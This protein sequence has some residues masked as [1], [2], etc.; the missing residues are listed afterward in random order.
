MTDI[1]LDASLPGRPWLKHYDPGVPRTLA[2]YPRSTL[3]DVV[4]EAAA[5]RPG[6][7]ALLF[8]GAS[9]SYRELD[10]LTTALAA[11]LAA[12]GV[13]RGE[14]VALVLPNSPQAIIAQFGAWKAGTVVA[15][16]NPLYTE[17]ELEYALNE[18]GAET[19][20]V[21]TPFYR[22]VKSLQAATRVRRV[23]VTNI[24]E[25]LPPF[26]RGLFVLVKEQREGHRITPQPGDVWLQDLLRVL[27][28][29]AQPAPP[30]PDD[31][32]L[33]LF[34]GGTTGRPRAAL[35][36]HHALLMSA[37]QTH[38]WFAPVLREWEDRVLLAMPLFHVYGNV[39]VLSTSLI[40]PNPIVL[41][42]NP[43]DLDDLIATIGKARPAFF[44]AVPTLLTALVN[45]PQ[46]AGRKVDFTSLKLCISGA[47]PLL[48]EAQQRF[49]A[50]TGG[51]VIDAYSLTEAMNAAVAQPVK[52][53]PKRGSVGMPLPDVEIR[54]VSIEGDRGD[55][56]PREPGQILMRAPQLMREYWRRPEE[57]AELIREGWLHTGDI[58]YLDED[59]FLFVVDR[60]KDVVKPG[61][62]QVWP[63]EV[64]EVI[65]AHPAV[66]EVGV[67]GVRDSH[68]GEVVK[69]WVVLREGEQLT[70]DDVQSWCRERMAAFKVPRIVEFPEA[71]PKSQIG[72]VLRRVLTA[73]HEGR[74][75]GGIARQGRIAVNGVD[76]YYEETGNGAETIVFAHGLMLNRRMFTDQVAALRREYRCVSFDFRGHGL[77][78]VARDGYDMDTLTDD[79]SALIDRLGAGPCHFVGHSMGGFVGLRLALRRPELVRSLILL[80][81]S[82]DAEPLWDAIQ[83]RML[84][85][86]AQW[87]GIPPLAGRVMPVLFGHTFLTDPTRIAQRE[88][89]HRQ[90]T[91]I[92]RDGIS[93]ALEGVLSRRGMRAEL[94]RISKPVLILVG[95]EDHAAPLS[96]A[97]SMRAGIRAA[98]LRVI[99]RAGHTMT[100]EAPE[101]VTT[102]VREFLNSVR[103]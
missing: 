49:E 70:P 9:L 40:G 52:G 79:T 13:Q 82:A 88:E 51:R 43:R 53:A 68:R 21:L 77:S 48:A 90:V 81:T 80:A 59:G 32:A 66:A 94:H 29:S 28:E 91:A 47:A 15:P 46:V 84:K 14:R 103:D 10:R 1:P 36:T 37:M 71:L 45:H 100:V 39:G 87:I 65:A 34:T 54:I 64:E 101:T 24:K 55:L 33:L 97:D 63:R 30:E 4:R 74:G 31:P 2:P 69:A 57:T 99:P 17:R 7:A 27:P 67:A 18:C 93:R 20:V 23:I 19:I 42:P 89:W 83:Y 50:L 72:K 25:F 44:P 5:R 61:G 98:A 35:G 6:H 22:K 102:A 58:G 76:L 38:A 78:A 95:E 62:F 73:D 41:V 75:D 96:R 11:G 3:L 16:L 26:L 92:T 12:Q 60:M 8:K 86:L 85:R 56:P